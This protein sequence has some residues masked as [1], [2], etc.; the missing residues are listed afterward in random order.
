MFST[1]IV[2]YNWS[3]FSRDGY[4]Q[5]YFTC[6]ER[7]KLRLER[8]ALLNHEL[9]QVGM[10]ERATMPSNLVEDIERQARQ[11]GGILPPRGTR[12]AVSIVAKK[13]GR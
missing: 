13:A 3:Y 6:N 2:P 12:V 10:W 5:P 7:G 4:L 11:Q 1:W 9:Q 8:C